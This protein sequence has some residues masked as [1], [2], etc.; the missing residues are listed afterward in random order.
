MPPFLITPDAACR[1]KSA[2]LGN[3]TGDPGL[4]REEPAADMKGFDISNGPVVDLVFVRLFDGEDASETPLTPATTDGVSGVFA[5]ERVRL[6]LGVFGCSILAEMV[7][8]S[9]RDELHVIVT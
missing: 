2:A 1:C 5:S 6:R 3:L 8:E 4:E 9:E 7:V